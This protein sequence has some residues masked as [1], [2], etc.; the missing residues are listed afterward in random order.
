MAIVGYA[1]VSS[2]DQD[3][4]VQTEKLTNSGCELIFSE[5]LTGSNANR[6]ELIKCLAYLRKDDTL[7]ITKLDR[8][9]R[10]AQ[11][12]LT[13]SSDL[14]AR[15]IT[16][17]VLDQNIDTSTAAGK[18]FFGM[19]SVFAEFE[20][21]L[22]EERQKDGIARA[23]AAGVYKGRKSTLAPMQA[24]VIELAQAGMPKAT[25]AVKLGISLSSV[26]NLAKGK[27]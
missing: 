9:G 19:L 24:K 18:C 5:K 11:D 4:T 1:R 23:K 3:L 10:S 14:D 22:R 27:K 2:T 13:I 20:L 17:K 16:L 6:P 12:L 8:L 21:N 26:Y 25:I 7:V 15:G